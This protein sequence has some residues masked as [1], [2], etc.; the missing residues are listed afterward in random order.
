MSSLKGFD[1]APRGRSSRW[2]RYRCGSLSMNRIALS[3][4]VPNAFHSTSGR[5]RRPMPC[6]HGIMSGC[7]RSRVMLVSSTCR[8]LGRRK[9][10]ICPGA[11][12]IRFPKP[13]ACRMSLWCL[14]LLWLPSPVVFPYQPSPFA[15]SVSTNRISSRRFNLNV[16]L[17]SIDGLA[18]GRFESAVF[19][20]ASSCC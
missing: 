19:R 11:I 15:F 1:F 7:S 14:S 8:K 4:A 6:R 20:M 12:S 3:K 17:V 13:S 9:T 2:M 5:D 18:S 10:A 16:R